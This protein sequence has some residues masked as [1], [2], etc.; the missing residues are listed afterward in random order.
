MARGFL[1]FLYRKILAL[2]LQTLGV[3]GLCTAAMSA[4]L[5]ASPCIPGTVADWMVS[6]NQLAAPIRPADCSWITQTPPDFGWPDLSSDAKYQV[7][8]TYPDGHTNTQATATNWINWPEALPAGYYA[9]RV[10]VTNGSGTKTSLTRHFTVATGASIFLVPDAATL[11]KRVLAKSHPRALPDAATLSAMLAQ[12]KAGLTALLNEVNGKLTNA[13]QPQPVSTSAGANWSDAHD[14]CKR[15]LNVALAWVATRQS[16]YLNSAILRLKNLAS[17][18]PTGATSYTAP[19]MDMGARE[20]TW[21]MALVYDW[22]WP[23]LDAATRAQVLGVLQTRTS[24]MYNDVIG[25]RSRVALY[26]RD[27]HGNLTV[28]VLAGIATILAGDLDDAR[29]WLAGAV[30]QAANS[31]SPWGGDDS[32]HGNGTTQGSWDMGDSLVPWYVLRWATGIDMAQKAWTRNWSNFIAYMI[33]P[34]TPAGNFGDGAETTPI[35]NWSRF[36]KAYTWFSPTP[37]GRWYISQPQMQYEDPTRI[38]VMLA[39][40]ADFT[41]PAPFPA[42]T[43]NTAVFRGIGWAAMHSDLANPNRVSVYFKSSPYSSYNHSHGDQNSFVINAGGKRLAIDSGYYDD[44]K[45]AHWYNWYKQT[46]AHN[47]ITYDGGLG[48]AIFEQSDKM[49]SGQ[50]TGYVH[51]SGYEILYG[52]ATPAYTGA[53]QKAQRALVYLPP[54]LVLVYDR[55]ASAIARQW[56]WNIH[57]VN[58]MSSASGTQASIQN[59][60]QTLCVTILG[61]PSTVFAQTN[62]FTANPV[63]T[64]SPQWHGTFRSTAKLTATEFVTLLNVGCATVA[65]SASKSGTIWSVKVGGKTLSID[66]GTGSITMGGTTQTSATVPVAPPTALATSA[67]PYAGKPL[68]VPGSFAVENFD[69]SGEGMAHLDTTGRCAFNWF[70][71]TDTFLAAGRQRLKRCIPIANTSTPTRPA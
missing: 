12:R 34:G 55:L 36:G 20:I 54:N 71:K 32:G 46:R 68:A 37:L 61:G 5:A 59:G 70:G 29:I 67:R 63:G 48:Q 45:T 13:P 7:T 3:A 17:W 49:G 19:G 35:E 1:I 40:P 27:S 14:E 6:S 47:A 33:P 43:A 58:Q 64:W 11:Y 22:L 69:L 38:E 39:P 18:N 28:T 10:A 4:S 44:Y 60:G 66:S 9:W 52:D 2:T 31:V 42:G 50:I 25:T 23:Q 51:G 21:T 15:T 30:P 24:V 57:A 56:E 62:A 8:L 41:P 16:Q 65:A 26:P 53:L